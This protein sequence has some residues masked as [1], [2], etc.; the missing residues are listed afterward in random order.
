[1][2]KVTFRHLLAHRAGLCHEAPVGNNYGDWD[3]TFDEHVR[4]IQDTWLKC[5]VGERFRYSNLGY[6]LVGHALA[7]RAGKPFPRLMREELLDP[8]GMTRSTFDQ[9][10]ALQ[11]ADRARGHIG[12]EAAP[13][14]QVP[15]LA[16][17]GLWSTA[18]DAARFVSLHLAGGA[19]GGRRLADADVLRSMYAPQ[20]P[21]PGQRAGYGLGVEVRPYRGA[22]LVSHGGGGYGYSADH[23]WI[24]EHRL[25]VVVL[26]NAEEG[27]GFV[28]DLADRALLGMLRAK[29]GDLPAGKPPAR[30][31]AP[32]AAPSPGELRRLEGT[33]LVG[34]QL[35]AFGLRDGRLHVT[36]G[37]RTK[38]LTALSPT[39]FFRGDDLYEFLPDDRGGVREVRQ[40]G[41]GGVSVLVPNDSPRDPEGPA[42]PGWGRFAGTYHAR[43]YGLDDEKAVGLKNGHL[44]WNGRLKLTEYRPGLFLTADGDTVGFGEGTVEYGNRHFRRVPKPGA[45][46]GAVPGKSWEVIDRPESLG[47][48]PAKLARAR[49][50]AGQ[51]DTAA[52]MVVVDGRVLCQWGDVSAKFMAHS[53]RKSLL[54]GLYGVYAGEGLIR[55][56]KTLADLRI[57]DTPPGLTPAE[58]RA[59]VKDLLRS[60]SGVYHPAA[61]ETPDMAVTR[62][63][64]G[65]HPPGTRWHYNNWDFNALG[66]IFERETGAKIFEAFKE[67]FA[68]PLGMED[69]RVADGTYQPGPESKH[70]GYPVRVTA[71]DLARYGLLYLRGG[72]WGG[73][74]VAP[75][76]WVRESTKPHSVTGTCGYGYMWWVAANGRGLPRVNLPDGSFWAW[77]TRGHYLVVVPALDLV[78]VHRVDTDVPGR[79]VT[80]REFGRLLRLILD[81][82]E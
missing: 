66:T 19:A 76:A 81:A 43:A 52:V 6:D 42:K 36:R 3:C 28:A 1:V 60:R 4:S 12:G 53:M 7:L 55:L 71:R 23:R 33:Y 40:H 48:S 24:P 47:W 20:F 65:S 31:K 30:A 70:P 73:R 75:A 80:D 17:G 61:L 39:R 62:P 10:L 2:D 51:L 72:A 45:R 79:E 44:Y 69:F 63:A 38:P 56:D 59:T 54:S 34:A 67:K 21:L 27:G 35:T 41:A 64:R 46:R 9:A 32:A 11:T 50:Y 78:V 14:L 68:D 8:L 26:S 57:D 15:M 82:R 18:R 58:A 5:R 49:A 16:A 74:R 25:G 77:G 22:T 37:G 29:L 13:P